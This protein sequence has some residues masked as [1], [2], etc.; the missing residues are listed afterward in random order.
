MPCSN[1]D[2]LKDHLPID[3]YQSKTSQNVRIFRWTLWSSACCM[4]TLERSPIATGIWGFFVVFFWVAESAS[5]ASRKLNFQSL[6]GFV[7]GW[8][9]LGLDPFGR[10]FLLE[11]FQDRF[12]SKSPPRRCWRSYRA[13][14]PDAWSH[15]TSLDQSRRLVSAI[16][17][18]VPN[19]PRI[20][21]WN[22]GDQLF[23][24][25]DLHL[26]T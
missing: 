2:I 15:W 6:V 1:G 17:G 10:R 4:R 16:W 26:S 12:S 22:I 23:L 25:Y 14:S 5:R 13:D 19:S 24:C 8:F 18:E 21:R 9:F 3:F 20:L 7:K 11:L